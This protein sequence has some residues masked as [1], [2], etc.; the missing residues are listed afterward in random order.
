MI[1]ERATYND[2]G[3]YEC[4]V[5]HGSTQI[6]VGIADLVVVA[7]PKITF[8]PEMP[9]VVRSGNHVII[10]CQTEGDRPI[11]VSWHMEDPYQSLPQT[12]SVRGESLVFNSITTSDTGRYACTA[13][14]VH[15]NITK[16]AEVIVNGREVIDR[17]PVNKVEEVSEGET[18]SLN[19][20]PNTDLPYGASVSN[21]AEGGRELNR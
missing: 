18:V 5:I 1:I 20:L 21:E 14:N 17:N 9:M 16:T 6:P 10:Y 13:R 12:V 19:C 7:L 8:Y 4:Y 15:G 3:Q 2:A 11:D